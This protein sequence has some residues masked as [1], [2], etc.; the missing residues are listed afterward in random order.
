[1]RIELDAETTEVFL[2]E[3]TER[4]FAVVLER[5]ST[6]GLQA[7]DHRPLDVAAAAEELG[8]STDHVRRLVTAGLLPR[9]PHTGRRVLIPRQAVLAMARG[10]S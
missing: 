8:V 10:E 7:D 2:A 5:A 4:L 1:M 3:L 6:G 9:V